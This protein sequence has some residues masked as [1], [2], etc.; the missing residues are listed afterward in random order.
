MKKYPCQPPR[1]MGSRLLLW[2]KPFSKGSPRKGGNFAV[3]TIVQ[4]DYKGIEVGHKFSIGP[5]VGQ[6]LAKLI[7]QTLNKQFS[8]GNWRVGKLVSG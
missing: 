2:G 8:P 7:R 4:G 5:A 3:D 6:I 1:G